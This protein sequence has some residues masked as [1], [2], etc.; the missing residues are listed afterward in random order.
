M[1]AA[2]PCCLLGARSAAPGAGSPEASSGRMIVVCVTTT[3][4]PRR[5]PVAKGRRKGYCSVRFCEGLFWPSGGCPARTRGQTLLKIQAQ[6][7]VFR[8]FPHMT[9]RRC[10]S[11]FFFGRQVGKPCRDGLIS[12]TFRTRFSTLLPSNSEQRGLLWQKI[13]AKNAEVESLC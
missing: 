12:M 1:F 7:C 3:I 10:R 13:T 4:L 9:F 11:R 6:G 2:Y 8:D 5:T